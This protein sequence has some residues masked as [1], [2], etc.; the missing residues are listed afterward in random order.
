MRE[1]FVIKQKIE[2]R[3]ILKQEL[4]GKIRAK[5]NMI[6]GISL[7]SLDVDL[8]DEQS[9]KVLGYV[10]KNEV[11]IYQDQTKEEEVVQ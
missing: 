8:L 1:F 2:N 3:E 11:V 5:K 9:R 10:S 7:D 6:D 4:L